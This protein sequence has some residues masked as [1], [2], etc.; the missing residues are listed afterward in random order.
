M[1]SFFRGDELDSE[2][3]EFIAA[4]NEFP[5][6]ANQAWGLI[7]ERHGDILFAQAI[8][9]CKSQAEAEDLLEDTILRVL[10][11]AGLYQVPK[12]F[13]KDKIGFLTRGWLIRIMK[14][15]HFDGLED[16]I[17]DDNGFGLDSQLITVS[18][19]PR[20][21]T[22]SEL[23]REFELDGAEGIIDQTFDVEAQSKNTVVIEEYL[24]TLTEREREILREIYRYY[25]GGKHTPTGVL[26]V[27]AKK[28]GTS[29]ENVQQIRYRSLKKLKESLRP[30][31]EIR[32]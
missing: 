31:I 19:K 3:M 4:R 30:K 27:I 22:F 12:D 25:E 2:L 21:T 18:G 28:F 14:N 9:I 6:E 10:E 8:K 16:K 7:Y 11:K 17:E 20:K 15:I 24:T 1:E 32:R 29:V 26:P 13:P 23:E 5:K